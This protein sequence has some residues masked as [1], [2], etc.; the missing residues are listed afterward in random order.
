MLDGAS[1]DEGWG[2][3]TM[4]I[5]V[6][7]GAVQEV[8]DPLERVHRRVRLDPG[9][10]MN[11]VTKSGTNTFHG[12]VLYMVRPGDVSGDVVLDERASARRRY[13]RARRRRR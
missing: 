11:I 9:P 12:E 3:Q 7:V 4:L 6:P 8:D 5:T 1:N 2:R 10:A 13:R